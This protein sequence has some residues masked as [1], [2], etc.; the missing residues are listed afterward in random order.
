MTRFQDVLERFPFEPAEKRTLLIRKTDY[1][2]HIYPPDNAFTSDNNY[3][4]VSTD[5]LLVGIYELWP[6]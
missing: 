6:S 3:L 4:T 1:L 2:H 5:T